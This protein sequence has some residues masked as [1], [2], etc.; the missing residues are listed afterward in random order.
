M[1]C[2][3]NTSGTA[4]QNPLKVHRRVHSVSFSWDVTDLRGRITHRRV[5]QGRRARP[6]CALAWGVAALPSGFAPMAWSSIYVQLSCMP[7]DSRTSV[8]TRLRFSLRCS[9]LIGR[10]A[11]KSAHHRHCQWP[12]R[13]L[14]WNRL[15]IVIAS[16]PTG[17][18]TMKARRPPAGGKPT[19]RRLLCAY[20][21]RTR[22]AR[23]C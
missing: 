1:I 8:T 20:D 4:A 22:T 19:Y 13:S 2:G 11:A 17:R 15:M 6:Y 12:R 3:S 16:A 21:E 10:R 5:S 18:R 9:C 7:V 14:Q 23:E